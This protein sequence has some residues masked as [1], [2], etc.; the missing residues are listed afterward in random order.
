MDGSGFLWAIGSGT[1]VRWDPR[2][3]TY[4]EFGASQGLPGSNPQ[5]LFIGPQGKTWLSFR[6][7]GL[8]RFDDPDWVSF[9]ELGVVEGTSMDAYAISTSGI[10]WICT[11]E[12]LSKFDGEQWT[13]Y[14]ITNGTPDGL[15]KYI[16]ID[17]QGNPW[18]QG[19]YGISVLYEPDDWVLYNDIEYE[20]NIDLR[21]PIGAHTAPDGTLWFAYDGGYILKFDGE[22]WYPANIQP[23]A[24]ALSS[25]GQ[26]WV[27]SSGSFG[28]P[29][30]I[31]TYVYGAHWH[32]DILGGSDPEY[33]IGYYWPLPFHDNTPSD[34]LGRIYPGLNGEIWI[35]SI[36]GVIRIRGSSIQLIVLDGVR[37]ASDIRD[38][39][40]T[41][42]GEI[43]LALSDGISKLVGNQLIPLHA[44]AG[45]LNN[46]IF[47]L[48]IDQ[49]QSLWIETSRGLQTFDGETWT[50][51][52]PPKSWL[53]DMAIA[54]NGDVWLT[55]G[56]SGASRW[57]GQD[58]ELFEPGSADGYF[59]DQVETVSVS[60][61]GLVCLGIQELGVSCY[62]GSQ[63]TGIEFD[64]GLVA[65]QIHDMVIDDSG[66]IYLITSDSSFDNAYLLQYDGASWSSVGIED[67]YSVLAVAPDGSVWLGKAAGGVYEVHAG[68]ISDDDLTAG[69][70]IEGV[71]TL[72]FAQDGSLWL[73]ADNGG[74]RY[75]GVQWHSFVPQDV[76]ISDYVREIALGE[77]NTIWFGGVGL[78]RYGEPLELNR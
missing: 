53:Y 59:D 16:T 57:N 54:P 10:L 70:A 40:I 24:F 51:V 33:V 2:Q 17:K 30:D 28:E 46:N 18:L 32:F 27:V 6:G 58:W 56:F 3:G 77:D 62:D 36:D 35:T 12:G 29:D 64:Q 5:A 69:S 63:W 43:Y 11:D 55:H 52:S 44:E 15:C 45:L 48:A 20:R 73:G 75:D 25:T 42:Y 65:D 76:L 31:V 72:Q 68:A 37:S 23:D 60:K 8:W 4:Q 74:W 26:P 1:I 66:G 38:I 61:H 49:E 47:E 71:N 13:A 39:E 50:T 34:D 19:T 22:Y 9:V 78:A 67:W 41:P 14:Q 21:N 7:E